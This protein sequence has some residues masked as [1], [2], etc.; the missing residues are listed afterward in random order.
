M[1]VALGA[2][3]LI[4]VP[5]THA[6]TYDATTMNDGGSGS[7]REAILSANAIDGH[8]I[9]NATTLSG[10]ILLQT[11]PLF[12]NDSVTINGPGS[13]TLTISGD[14]DDDGVADYYESDSQIFEAAG[15]GFESTIEVE[16]NGMSLTDGVA[17]PYLYSDP[18]VGDFFAGADG[19]ALTANFAHI[20]L[21]DMEVKDSVATG[22]GGGISVR[23]GD[24][25]LTSSTVSGNTAFARGGGIHQNASGN[26]LVMDD[27]VLSGN[28]SGGRAYDSDFDDEYPGG[29]G[30]IS[31]SADDIDIRD[32][33]ISGNTAADAVEGEAPNAIGGGADLEGFG[34]SEDPGIEIRR[35]TFAD[36][37]AVAYAGGLAAFNDTLIA[38]STFSGN[39][40]PGGAGGGIAYGGEGGGM[41]LSNSTVSGNSAASGGG[42]AALSSRGEEYATGRTSVLN[43]TV[44]GNLGGG[45]SH[46]G[47]A[48]VPPALPAP[49]LSSTIVA[50]NQGGDLAEA[51][52]STGFTAA[53]S[54][55]EACAG[56]FT[57]NSS[58]AGSNVFGLDPDLG[59]LAD[60][61]GATET[62]LPGEES[63]VVDAGISNDFETDQRGPGNA[64]VVD[65]AADQR[66]GS[67]GTDIGAVELAQGAGSAA[68]GAATCG[69]T[70][71]VAPPVPVPP[72]V[73]GGDEGKKPRK[74][75]KKGKGKK[76]AK[77]CK[78]KKGKK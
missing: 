58:P 54:L 56:P 66:G 8:D 46:Y 3:G 70:G 55:V 71:E 65:A 36:N 1:G 34:F 67:D 16:I 19:G 40:V 23:N 76:R 73:G 12:I 38:D 2:T 32:S 57:L 15:G 77:K 39:S 28:A 63:P 37:D 42:L 4:A 24:L 5:A 53:N 13:G 35:T 14:T 25:E 26:A 62:M 27:V 44:A 74:C 59:P 51:G 48:A 18:Y 72:I 9:V 69:T 33:S 7:L 31:A 49:L 47:Y 52:D 50:D 45:I 29:G 75:K 11:G 10:T 43:S 64:R 21:D 78:K 6:A 22:N 41:K 20:T 30:G 61:G 17:R 68:A 60:N